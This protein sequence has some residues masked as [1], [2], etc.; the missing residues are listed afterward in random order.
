MPSGVAVLLA[1]GE[2]ERLYTG[3]SVLVS[4]ATEGRPASGLASFRALAVLLDPDLT[5]RAQ[6]PEATPSLSWAGRETFSSSLAEL[7]DLA[8]ELEGVSIHACSASV[9]TMGLSPERV[10]EAGLDG[11]MSTPHFLRASGNTALLFV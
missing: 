10:T 1:A 6:E 9:E 5:R 3:L 11:V 4:T 8:V 7:R 2:L